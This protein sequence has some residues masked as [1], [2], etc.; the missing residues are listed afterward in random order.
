MLPQPM[1]ISSKAAEAIEKNEKRSKKN[2]K[3]RTLPTITNDE[4]KKRKCW[5]YWMEWICKMKLPW[6]YKF[7]IKK[8]PIIQTF[9]ICAR[10][11]SKISFYQHLRVI[12]RII[13]KDTIRLIDLGV[14]TNRRIRETKNYANCVYSFSAHS[15]TM[16]Y[17]IRSRYVMNCN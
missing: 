7:Y 9:E 5:D 14:F 8:I 10:F 3:K 4:T 12:L 17:T 1:A 13:Y 11:L 16:D 15:H 6:E 2:K